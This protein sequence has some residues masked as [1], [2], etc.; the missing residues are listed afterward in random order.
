MID[1]IKTDVGPYAWAGQYQQT[2]TPRGGGIFKREWWQ[3]WE[4]PSGQFPVFDYVLASLDSAFT[5]QERNDPSALTIW[6]IFQNEEGFNR[7]MLVHAWRKHLEFSGPRNLMALLPNESRGQWVV[8]TQKHWGL[9]EWVKYTCERFKVDHLLI[10]GK[11]SG[12]SAAQEM[13]N[14]YGRLDFGVQICTVKGSKEARALAAQPTFSQLLVYAP[15][16]DWAEMVLD[17]MES[18][19]KHK[20]RD[21]TD[22]AT[23]AIKFMRDQGLLNTDQEARAIEAE[24][25]T[26][27][28][29]R[30]KKG[31]VADRYFG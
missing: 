3:L 24:E 5:E 4:S 16:R 22:S 12:I 13:Q 31:G 2:P 30:H 9:M 7:A 14:R 11:A 19:P 21:L 26:E 25:Q 1:A 10:E 27:W 15:A 23:Q 17:E 18:F 8:R 20:Y 29:R 6:G 28:L